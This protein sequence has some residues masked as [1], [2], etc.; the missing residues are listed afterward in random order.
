MVAELLIV[1]ELILLTTDRALLNRRKSLAHHTEEHY[2]INERP[3]KSLTT[4][5][6]SHLL[7][8]KARFTSPSHT[9]TQRSRSVPAKSI[10]EPTLES[11]ETS[12]K[13]REEKLRV[14][15]I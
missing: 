5:L 3:S 10:R 15:G 12:R 14:F 11:F 4:H 13:L 7:S 2:E 8:F 9:E 6:L 1:C